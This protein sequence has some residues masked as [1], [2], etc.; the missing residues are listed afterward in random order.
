MSQAHGQKFCDYL[1]EHEY[2]NI[3][4]LCACG[5]CTVVNF[6]GGKFAKHVGSHGVIG[7]K[8]TSETRRKISEIQ[9]G[10][11]LTE[12]HKN[13]I[14]IGVKKTLLKDETIG[15]KIRQKL[16]GKSKSEEHKDKISKTRKEKL[17]SGDI[18]INRDKISATV[19]QRYLDGGFEW[20]T[21][22]YTSVKTGITCNYRSS[23]ERELMEL[24]DNDP[25][26]ATWKYEPMSLTYVHENQTR[27]YIPDFQVVTS[28]HDYL[29]E[30]K[31]PTLTDTQVNEAKRRSAIEFCERNGWRYVTWASGDRL[32]SFI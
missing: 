16:K 6:F 12:D 13:K 3:W 28:D 4:P 26:I 5:C 17:S 23:W 31:P 19:T 10:R 20:S 27:R 25:T 7:L 32:L 22:Q 11:K 30:V 2:G 1:V 9:R 14:G 15:E 18:V 29:V 24:L 8:R 21:G